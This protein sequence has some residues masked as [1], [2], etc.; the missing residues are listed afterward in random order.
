LKTLYLAWQDPVSRCWKPV[1]R[2][3][4][5]GKMYQFV[6][7]RGAQEAARE[8]GFE[9]LLAFP[10]FD[11]VY[12]STELFPLFSNR[13]PSHS[14]EDYDSFIEW[15]AIPKEQ[16]D[17]FALLTRS[18]GRRATDSL[19][20]FPR[21]QPDEQGEYHIHFFAH[22]LRH[23][24]KT[25]IERIN[26]LEPREVILLLHDFQNKYDP[27]ALALRTEDMILVGHCPRYLLDDAY[28]LIRECSDIEIQVE[29][30]N[31]IPAPL[32]YRL[33]CNLSA[34][35]PEDF[36]PFTSNVYQPIPSE[37]PVI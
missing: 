37:K 1:G 33:L 15:L 2:L 19:E 35:W 9:P 12:E 18:G 20:V 21:P 34:C 26:K 31:L 4:F 8:C 28:G 36:H 27:N 30:I 14:R 29:R 7:T 3:T 25:A 24:P 22:G 6:Y 5:D 11:K 17:P 13:I 10:E 16:D 23:L 32:Q